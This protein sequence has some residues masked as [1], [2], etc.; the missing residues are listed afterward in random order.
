MSH[1]WLFLEFL[2]PFS[3]SSGKT[4]G[5]FE[6]AMALGRSLE[7]WGFKGQRTAFFPVAFCFLTTFR[8]A[9][10]KVPWLCCSGSLMTG[11][12]VALGCAVSGWK[13][14]AKCQ[15]A[16]LY[17]VM[18]NSRNL[19]SKRHLSVV[20]WS[21]HQNKCLRKF[22]KNLLCFFSFLQNVKIRQNR[23]KQLEPEVISTRCSRVAE[24]CVY[25]LD[26]NAVTCQLLS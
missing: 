6:D 8:S 5:T 24:G 16:Q 25:C 20:Y 11:P 15:T 18:M 13:L 2:P 22:F 4:A 26:P 3:T 7:E 9:S 1:S 12:V 21:S 17:S 19:K 14:A 10:K 23:T